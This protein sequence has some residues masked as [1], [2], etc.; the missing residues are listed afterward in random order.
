MK[1]NFDKVIDRTHTSCVKYDLRQVVFEKEDVIPM[2]VA[3]MDFETPDFIRDAVIRRASHPIYGYTFRD[4]DYYQPVIGWMQVHHDWTIHRDH[5]VFSPGVVPA[6]SFA[7]KAFTKPGDKIIIQSPVYPPIFRAVEDHNR[8]VLNNLLIEEGNSYHVDFGLLEEQAKE[9]AMLILCNPH[10]PVGRCW[11]RTELETI[12]QI[13][14][15]H[16]VLVFSD[17]IHADLVMPGF[18]HQ[19]FANLSPEAADITITAHA[20][21]KTFNLAG[22]ATSSVIISN[23]GLRASFSQLIEKMHLG[24]GN[25]FG[26]VASTAAYLHGEPW[27]LQ[28]LDYLNGNIGF[29]EDFIRKNIPALN[30]FR[31]EATYMI[32][33]DFRNFNLDDKTLKHKLIREAGLGFNSGT[34]FG[35]GGEGFMRMNIACPRSIVTEALERLRKMLSEVN[36]T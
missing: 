36:L 7:V 18:R 10:N 33:L 28:L 9:A 12:A 15:K 35:P 25:L 19:V 6:L 34:D 14:L 8:I 20:P 27:R 26:S 3:D 22:L 17:E 1:Y 32:W 13:C 16:R 23:P 24:M 2:W 5:I 11:N 21:S 30:M 29:T 4:A 31:P